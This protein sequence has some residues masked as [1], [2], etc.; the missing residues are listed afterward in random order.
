MAAA[1]TKLIVTGFAS[2]DI[3]DALDQEIDT[4]MDGAVEFA[5]AGTE[6]AMA[7]MFRDVYAPGEPE[8]EAVS[9]RIE[10]VLARD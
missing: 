3:L 10:R 6:P 9:T 4:E 7:A 5:V 8:P 1:R 2:S